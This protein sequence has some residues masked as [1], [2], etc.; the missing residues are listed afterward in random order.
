MT[1]KMDLD[2]GGILNRSCLGMTLEAVN[3]LPKFK[4]QQVLMR[5]SDFDL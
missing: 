1:Q 5:H 4:S 2:S 3:S